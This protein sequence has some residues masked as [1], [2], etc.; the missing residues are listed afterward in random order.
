VDTLRELRAL[1]PAETRLYLILGEDNLAGFPRWREAEELVRLAQPIVVHRV[2]SADGLDASA[3][4]PEART[5]LALG[6]L[7]SPALSVS[8]TELRAAL[9]RGEACG[10]HFS[11][12]LGAHVAR[13][14]LYRRP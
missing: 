7:A 5:R 6:L 12:A 4:S 11:P 13:R 10:E 8:S 3:F 9:A 14:G 2:G 1:V